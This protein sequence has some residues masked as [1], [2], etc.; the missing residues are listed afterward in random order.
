MGEK[1]EGGSEGAGLG[2]GGSVEEKAEGGSEGAGLGEGGSV[3]ERAEADLG[4]D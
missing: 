1:A 2:E 3:E 4:V